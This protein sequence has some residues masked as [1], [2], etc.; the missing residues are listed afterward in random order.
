MTTSR[1]QLGPLACARLI[2][3]VLIGPVMMSALLLG[4]PSAVAQ[5][6]Q[7]LDAA[8]DEL[9]RRVERFLRDLAASTGEAERTQEIF[10]ELLEG[11]MLQQQESLVGP[12]AEQA[13]RLEQVYGECRDF[14]QVGTARLGKD[15]V[16]LTYLYKCEQFPVVWNVTFY[17][18]PY[19]STT[20]GDVERWV[21]V[22]LA[23]H[24][25]IQS[26]AMP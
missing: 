11:S 21:V 5:E 7:V 12:L 4:H 18:K 26:L 6:P 25:D 2:G 24:T 10:D 15:V 22:A 16:T 3:L 1:W 19:D 20:M 9:G 13:R 23:W 14:E 17:R 8:P